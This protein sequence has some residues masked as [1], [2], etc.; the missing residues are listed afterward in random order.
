MRA[1]HETGY[2]FPGLVTALSYHL[3]W[4][5]GYRDREQPGGSHLAGS[6]AFG[7][8]APII[9]CG[10][11]REKDGVYV[12]QPSSLH[13]TSQS[14]FLTRTCRGRNCLPGQDDAEYR[15]QGSQQARGSLRNTGTRESYCYLGTL[16]P[17]KAIVTLKLNMFRQSVSLGFLYCEER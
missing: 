15:L 16:V 17:G 11:V 3:P 12:S 8:G 9:H 10:L 6:M 1:T 5:V 2:N 14:C 7:R 13:H 4:A